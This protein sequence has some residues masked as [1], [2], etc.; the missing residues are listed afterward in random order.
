M[1]T[2]LL[3]LRCVQMGISMADLQYLTLGMVLD[4]AVESG[5]DD[6]EYPFAATQED[7]DNL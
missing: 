1:T 3:L 7:M 6:E 5:N 2:A 4:M